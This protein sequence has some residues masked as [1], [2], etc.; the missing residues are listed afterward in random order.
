TGTLLMET[1]RAHDVAFALPYAYCQCGSAH[2]GLRNMKNCAALLENAKDES[3]Y[4]DRHVRA[5]ISVIK[6][7]MLVAQGRTGEALDAV[8]QPNWD[9]EPGRGMK[10]EY[11]AT[12]ALTL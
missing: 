12:R 9:R 3:D 7:R 4:D 6:T 10:A 1:A 2:L 8:P 5:H 11:L